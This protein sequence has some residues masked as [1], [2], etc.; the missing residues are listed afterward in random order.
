[1]SDKKILIENLATVLQKE[2]EYYKRQPKTLDEYL[3]KFNES[4][5]EQL[6]ELYKKYSQL[7]LDR[8]V[9][10]SPEYKERMEREY[11]EHLLEEI[12][13]DHCRT[14][15]L[16]IH[17]LTKYCKLSQWELEEA[18]SMLLYIPPKTVLWEGLKKH[19]FSDEENS[20]LWWISKYRELL[21]KTERAI[22]SGDLEGQKRDLSSADT[23]AER[24][25]S[26]YFFKPIDFIQWA[27]KNKISLPAKME[28]LVKKH[29]KGYVDL[30]AQ[31]VEYQFKIE[32]L[33]AKIID[34]EEQLKPLNRTTEKSYKQLI[35][36]LAYTMYSVNEYSDEVLA[37]FLPKIL[38]D[39]QSLRDDADLQLPFKLPCDKTITKHYNN[40]IYTLFHQNKFFI[41]TKLR[42]KRRP[43]NKK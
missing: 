30:E 36:I 16:P 39:T 32:K 38:Q 22:E 33:E 14:K 42:P 9:R 10:E 31:C 11:I 17:I 21:I 25:W 29:T 4:T 37:T 5:E 27:K 12:Y 23:T 6:L 43:K 18:V 34:L 28:N 2:S 41:K 3:V 40:S 13:Y 20:R 35:F 1:M 19:C 8:K 15:L 26:S 24:T 7:Q